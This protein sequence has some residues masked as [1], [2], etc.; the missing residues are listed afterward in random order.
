MVKVLFSLSRWKQNGLASLRKRHLL[1]YGSRLGLVETSNASS[2]LT[3]QKTSST[4]ETE[5]QAVFK[6]AII[7]SERLKLGLVRFCG[8]S[9]WVK[10]KHALKRKK[11]AL[12]EK[13]QSER[14]RTRAEQCFSGRFRTAAAPPAEP[15]RDVRTEKTAHDQGGGR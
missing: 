13:R 5:R 8:T 3:Q 7:E 4:T 12:N 10:Q 6:T 15:G 1:G 2:G 11:S 14:S 9:L